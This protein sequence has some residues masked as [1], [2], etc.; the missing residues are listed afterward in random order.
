MVPFSASKGSQWR[1]FWLH[2]PHPGFKRGSRPN[3]A[4]RPGAYPE[5][6]LDFGIDFPALGVD[7]PAFGIDFQAFGIDFAALGDDFPKCFG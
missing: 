6:F 4:E 1:P 5:T 7:F 2:F 3:R